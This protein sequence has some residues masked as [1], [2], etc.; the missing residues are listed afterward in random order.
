[1]SPGAG[2]GVQDIVYQQV[3]QAVNSAAASAS[4]CF[5]ALWP[6][7]ASVQRWKS[8]IIYLVDL[9]EQFVGIFVQCV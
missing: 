7:T 9:L 8:S 6:F 5:L 4:G 1:M 3:L 2:F